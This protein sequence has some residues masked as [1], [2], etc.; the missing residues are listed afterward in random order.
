EAHA[1]AVAGPLPGSRI[2]C[3]TVG[4]GQAAEA[5]S[6]EGVLYALQRL[7]ET[8]QRLRLAREP[9]ILLEVAL[10]RLAP[11]SPFSGR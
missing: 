7:S 10:V 5:L 3:T 11:G 1:L 9:R 2:V 4:R 6:E 8:E